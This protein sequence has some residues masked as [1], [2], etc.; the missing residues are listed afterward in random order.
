MDIFSKSLEETKGAVEALREIIVESERSGATV[1]GL[2]GNLGAGKTTFVQCVAEAFGVKEQITS[3]TFVIMKFYKISY[4]R[5]DTLI[6]IDAYRLK[7][8]DELRKLGID[9]ILKNPKNLILIEWADLVADVLP[10]DTIKMNFE[11]VDDQTRKIT[12]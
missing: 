12:L 9:N 6:H 10:D 11:F 8:G 5:F 4:S 7:G 1:V 2:V 3:P